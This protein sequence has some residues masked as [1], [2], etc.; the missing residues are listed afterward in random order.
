MKETY[1]AHSRNGKP[2]E[3]WHR[4]ED[5][6]DAVAELAR[7]FADDFH[8]GDWGYLAGLEHDLGKYSNEFQN[9]L[10]TLVIQMPTLKPSLF[11]QIIQQPEPSMPTGS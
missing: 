9:R 3:E 6:L 11:V 1:Y 4:L 5:H 10:L 7:I 8:A 2:P